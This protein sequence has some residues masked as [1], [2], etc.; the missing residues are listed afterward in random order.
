MIRK[1]SIKTPVIRRSLIN[2]PEARK[3]Y[4]IPKDKIPSR[5]NNIQVSSRPLSPIR[6]IKRLEPLSP[7]SYIWRIIHMIIT[8]ELEFILQEF[9][10][11]ISMRKKEEGKTFIK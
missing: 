6:N 2:S 3:S 9:I 4:Y 10:G 7:S 5:Y 1:S 11:L 8:K